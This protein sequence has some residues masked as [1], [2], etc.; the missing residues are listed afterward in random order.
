MGQTL[1]LSP[2]SDGFIMLLLLSMACPVV[3]VLELEAAK[4]ELLETDSQL[5]L[6]LRKRPNLFVTARC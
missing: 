3:C 4:R 6:E 5:T 1:Q 2:Q